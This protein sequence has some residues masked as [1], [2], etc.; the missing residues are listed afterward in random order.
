[1]SAVLVVLAEPDDG[2]GD[3]KSPASLP[4]QADDPVHGSPVQIRGVLCRFEPGS[5]LRFYLPEGQ[6][7]IES[8]HEP[9]PSSWSILSF[10]DEIDV[11]HVVRPGTRAGEIVV[12]AAKSLHKTLILSHL[13]E[14]TSRVGL[15]LGMLDLADA[16]VVG[17]P[18]EAGRYGS[19]PV[20]VVD[21]SGGAAE[22]AAFYKETL[23]RLGAG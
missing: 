3:L 19:Y 18:E 12:L 20:R 13:D 21:D 6:P 23:E 2:A 1:V 17:S 14:S 8:G 10:L 22:W 11:V 15:S 4:T 5:G 7:V 9:L 16:V